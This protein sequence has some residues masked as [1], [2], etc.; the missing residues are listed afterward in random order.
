[1][2]E[3]FVEMV[4][5]NRVPYLHPGMG[6]KGLHADPDHKGGVYAVP[7]EEIDQGDRAVKAAV[8]IGNDASRDEESMDQS[9]Q[10][11]IRVASNVVS[12]SALSVGHAV[13]RF[14]QV[15]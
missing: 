13:D 7:G 14:R 4:V 1:M 10:T 9:G 15:V 3:N 12:S 11:V 6:S 2:D 5:E 8:L